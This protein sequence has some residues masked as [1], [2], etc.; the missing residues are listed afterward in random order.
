MQL[1][2]GLDQLIQGIGRLFDELGWETVDAWGNCIGFRIDLCW[3]NLG[4]GRGLLRSIWVLRWVLWGHRGT[5][6]RVRWVPTIASW[7]STIGAWLWHC[8]LLREESGTCSVHHSC[9]KTWLCRR[10]TWNHSLQEAHHV[11]KIRFFSWSLGLR[12]VRNVRQSD[13]ILL[14]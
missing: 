9:I 14:A 11:G 6:I 1:D 2:L 4:R 10:V 8:L 13:R 3:R 5:S 12:P 7:R